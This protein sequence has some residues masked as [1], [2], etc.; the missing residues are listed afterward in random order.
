MRP[1]KLVT[2]RNVSIDNHYMIALGTYLQINGQLKTHEHHNKTELQTWTQITITIVMKQHT[3]ADSRICLSTN[4]W[5]YVVNK[6]VH[7]LYMY[8]WQHKK[9]QRRWQ[10]TM[11]CNKLQGSCQPAYVGTYS[12]TNKQHFSPALHA[13]SYVNSRCTDPGIAKFENWFDEICDVLWCYI[14]QY[15]PFSFKYCKHQTFIQLVTSKSVEVN[16]IT[17]AKIDRTKVKYEFTSIQENCVTFSV[18]KTASWIKHTAME[19]GILPNI[20]TSSRVKCS[21]KL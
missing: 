19:Y 4:R 18:N 5:H 7:H 1:C 13:R 9:Q 16:R 8:S 11:A 3:I 6:H 21:C 20:A 12:A 10:Q 17:L 2:E 14:W 15:G